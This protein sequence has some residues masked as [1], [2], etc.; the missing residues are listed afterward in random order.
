MNN[1]CLA[2]IISAV[3]CY[4][5]KGKNK[6]AENYKVKSEDTLQY[7]Q[8]SFFFQK[9]IKDVNQVPYYIYKLNVNNGVKDSVTIN[10]A[11][12]N[13]LVKPFLQ[14]DITS[15]KLKPL[16]KETIFEDQTTGGYTIDYTAKDKTLEIQSIDILLK[17]D[18]K[19]VKDIF[20]RKFFNYTDSTAIEQLSWTPGKRFQIIRSV[21]VNDKENNYRTTVVWNE[22]G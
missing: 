11:A 17:E 9:D 14:P 8:T 10:T 1:L 22:N 18:G 2:I 3:F 12:F 16:Y 19:N 15:A 5:C 20:I 7:F 6:Q 13:E 4:G 21:K